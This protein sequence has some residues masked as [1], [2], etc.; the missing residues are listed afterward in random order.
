MEGLTLTGIVI[1]VAI[2]LA[3]VIAQVLA[4]VF[5]LIDP[6]AAM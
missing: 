4:R 2:V 6:S 5:D 3:V 1:S